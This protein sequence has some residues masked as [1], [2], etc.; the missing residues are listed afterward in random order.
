MPQP[1][2]TSIHCPPEFIRP[3]QVAWLLRTAV[4]EKEG[5]SVG[6]GHTGRFF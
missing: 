4:T 2:I 3:Q 5:A 1:Q 6:H